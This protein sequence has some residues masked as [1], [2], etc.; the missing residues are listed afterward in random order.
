MQPQIKVIIGRD[1]NVKM[2][3][4]GAEGPACLKLTRDLEVALTGGNQSHLSRE[5]KPEF[6]FESDQNE[7]E[8][9]EALHRAGHF[10]G[11]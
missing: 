7:V 8:A 10:E 6:A 1:G 3:V 4:V 9:G 2:E 11:F 5:F